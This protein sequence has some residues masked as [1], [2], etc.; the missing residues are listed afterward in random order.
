[1]NTKFIIYELRAKLG[2]TYCKMQFATSDAALIEAYALRNGC[3]R[4]GLTF[5]GHI[6]PMKA[7]KDGKFEDTNKNVI[8]L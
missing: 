1:M 3:E 4:N 7:S 6:A 5:A 2:E 8:W